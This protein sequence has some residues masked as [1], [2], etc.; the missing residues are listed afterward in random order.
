M[1]KSDLY[2]I[3]CITRESTEEEIKR[4]YKKLA[5]KFHPD[6]NQ[7]IHA[8]EAFKKVY[9]HPIT[10]QISHA[11]TT[12]KDPEKKSFYDKYGSEE[13]YR[14]KYTQQHN[15]Q[16]QDE[17]VDPFDLFEMFFTGGMGGNVHFQRGGR[18]F[19]RRYNQQPEEAEE[20]GHQQNQRRAGNNRYVALI[21]LLPFLLIVLYSFIPYLLQTVLLYINVQKPLYQFTRDEEFYKKMATSY[22]KIDYFVGDKFLNKYTNKLDIRDVIFLFIQ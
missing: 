9:I 4:S 21:Q 15:H 13:E 17:E 22:N 10:L 3:L 5:I 12:L 18:V 20:Q 16:Y 2:E 7:S 14:E 19:R 1:G 6:K 11:F 8:A